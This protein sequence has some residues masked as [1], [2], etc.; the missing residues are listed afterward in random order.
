MLCCLS[1]LSPN[2]IIR[3][4][5]AVLIPLLLEKNSS[6]LEMSLEIIQGQRQNFKDG[7]LTSHHCT[8]KDA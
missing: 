1:K 3:D 6:E 2:Y 4:F 7:K 5:S 8:E